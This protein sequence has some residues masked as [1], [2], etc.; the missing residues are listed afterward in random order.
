MIADDFFHLRLSFDIFIKDFL[1][2]DFVTASFNEKVTAFL[3]A[4]NVSHLSQV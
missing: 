2:W 3:R 4:D 1:D